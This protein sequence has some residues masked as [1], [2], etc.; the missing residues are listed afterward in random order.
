M[1]SIM[2]FWWGRWRIYQALSLKNIKIYKGICVLAEGNTY[3]LPFHS[4]IFFV[5]H[6]FFMYYAFW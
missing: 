2:F 5:G 1:M 6:Y 4:E 3:L